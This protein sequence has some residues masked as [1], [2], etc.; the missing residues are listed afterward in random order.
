MKLSKILSLI[1]AAVIVLGVASCGADPVNT[2]AGGTQAQTT[3][4]NTTASTEPAQTEA[5]TE[6]TSTEPAAQLVTEADCTLG[7]PDVGQIL[8]FDINYSETMPVGSTQQITLDVVLSGPWP[9]IAPEKPFESSDECVLTVDKEGNVT[10][11]EPGTATITIRYG[12]IEKKIDVTVLGVF[13][14]PDDP[15]VKKPVIYLYPTAPMNVTLTFAN[16][17]NLVTTYPKYDGSWTV[18]ADTDGTLTDANGRRYYA[19]FFDEAKTYE[20]DFSTGFYVTADEAI[21]F[22]EE[23][24]ALLGF[25]EREANEFIMF[26]LPVLERNGQSVVYFEQTAEREAECPIDVSTAPDSVLRVIIHIKKVASPVDIAE[27][28]LAPFERHG[29]TLVEWGGTEY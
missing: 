19:L 10:A 21:P 13:P 8:R 12:T 28:T 23:K 25:T 26:W 29:F 5:T 17:A 7:E 6:T 4:T 20:V 11:L 18:F 22:L 15:Y 14:R 24:L 1:I 27:Q 9:D 16:A 2:D 3:L